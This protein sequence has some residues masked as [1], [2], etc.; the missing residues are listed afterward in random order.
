[1]KQPLAHFIRT[2]ID[3]P[4]EVELQAILDIFHLTVYQKGAI[5]KHHDTICTIVGFLISG[6]VRLYTTKKNGEKITGRV[7]QK[8]N[9]VTDLI[10]VR[11]R[12][13]TAIS[14]EAL[15]KVSMLVASWEE[16]NKLLGTNLTFNKLMREFMAESIVQMGKLYLLF[17]N[18][19]AKER[20][21]FMLERYPDLQQKFP[22]HF[23]AHMIGVT[24]T[25]LSRIRKT[26][27]ISI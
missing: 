17:L 1:M 13:K 3:Q 14:I 26:A 12:E 8:N 11:T 20:Y 19:T 27:S 10:S 2:T 5:I 6:N 15:E 21:Q 23:I 24:P 22:L 16:V 7:V 18:G 25:Q 4:D 9:F